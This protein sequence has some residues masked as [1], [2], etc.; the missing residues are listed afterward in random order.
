MVTLS[1]TFYCITRLYFERSQQN[2][3]DVPENIKCL[4]GSQDSKRAQYTACYE[5]TF[6][7]RVSSVPGLP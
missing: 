2:N 7:P 1:E 3:T 6:L 5:N 4:R